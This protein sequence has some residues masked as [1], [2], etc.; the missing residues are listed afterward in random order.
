[1]T[2]PRYCCF[3]EY[4]Q[5]AYYKG[6]GAEQLA[7][8]SRFLPT[9]RLSI[10]LAAAVLAGARLAAASIDAAMK[11]SLLSRCAKAHAS[12]ADFKATNDRIR[13]RAARRGA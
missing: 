2:F 13:L 8:I 5:R 7:A 1:M 4:R 11:K 12:A 9:G 10:F 3:S 6:R